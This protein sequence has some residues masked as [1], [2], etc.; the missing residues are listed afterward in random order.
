MRKKVVK[1]KIE[2]EGK[3]GKALQALMNAVERGDIAEDA[4]IRPLRPPKRKHSFANTW[5][6]ERIEATLREELVAHSLGELLAK[7]RRSKGISAIH[8]ARKLGVSRSQVYQSESPDANLELASLLRHAEALGYRV[9]VVLKPEQPSS[10][11]KTLV[12]V[13]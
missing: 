8:Q 6:P 2:L 5:T 13:L 11:D 4:V 3:P 1:K 9:E 7:A 12:A 10:K